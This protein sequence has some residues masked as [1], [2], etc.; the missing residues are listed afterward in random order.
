MLLCPFFNS[1]LSPIIAQKK[2]K[3]KITEPGRDIRVGVFANGMK[4]N[5]NTLNQVII[6]SG[7]TYV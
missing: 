5:N 4:A 1:I 7:H 6:K 2:K 3:I